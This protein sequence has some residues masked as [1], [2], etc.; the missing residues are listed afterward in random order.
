MRRKT[1]EGGKIRSRS[2]IEAPPVP[3][4]TEAVLAREGIE[5]IESENWE[6]DME[7]EEISAF[8]DLESELDDVLDELYPGSDDR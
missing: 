7:D 8:K 5:E 1:Q 6:P 2:S 4:E 3:M